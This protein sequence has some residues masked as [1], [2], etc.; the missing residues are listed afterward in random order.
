[1]RCY[2]IPVLVN[3]RDMYILANF[4]SDGTSTSSGLSRINFMAMLVDQIILYS[5]M[6][7][8]GFNISKNTARNQNSHSTTWFCILVDGRD[9]ISV[10]R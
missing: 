2:T 5:F 1:M 9:E 7:L 3:D 6:L 4:I 10:V 8:Y